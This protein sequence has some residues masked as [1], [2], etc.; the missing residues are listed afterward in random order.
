MIEIAAIKNFFPASIRDD[1]G[2]Q[3]LMLKEYIQCQI[4]E[5]LSNS[6]F[7]SRLSFIGGTNLRLIKR[8]ERFSEDLD[9]DC[10]GMS[11]DD[12]LA[13][14]DGVVRHLGYLGYEVEPK[15][16]E[17]DGLT[18]FRRSLYFPQLLFGLQLSGYRNERF[19][20]KVE[21]EDQGIPYQTVPAFVQSC[22]FFFPIPVP[23]DETLCAMKISALL[24]RGKGRDFYDVM[25]LL[26]QTRPDYRFL[27]IRHGIHDGQELK[28]ALELRS[29]EVD[30][31]NKQKDVGHLMFSRERASMIVNFRSFLDT[32][33]LFDT[34]Y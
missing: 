12:F 20:I 30:L 31:V 28:K 16:R 29:S 27:S 11:K 25:F 10:K 18:A 4:L 32:L 24:D 8:I 3:K 26:G 2:F 6:P 15:E 5:Y 17:H 7:I 19:L 13:M 33:N 22:G 23:P 21:M 1:T 34:P 9:F 14:T